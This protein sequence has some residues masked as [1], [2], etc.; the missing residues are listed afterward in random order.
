MINLV[1]IKKNYIIII[2]II[3]KYIYICSAYNETSG[4]IAFVPICTYVAMLR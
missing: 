3:I 2:K 1:I 4:I